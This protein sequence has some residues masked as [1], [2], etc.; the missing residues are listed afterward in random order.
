MQTWSVVRYDIDVLAQDWPTEMTGPIPDLVELLAR[1]RA[2]DRQRFL[3]RSDGFVDVRVNVFL[4]S[5]RMRMLASNTNRDYAQS[6]CLWLNFLQTRGRVWSEA[7]DE[8]VEDFEFWR[9]TDPSNPAPVG[10]SAFSKDVAACKKFYSWAA[11]RFS[12]IVDVFLCVD[13]P[14]SKRSA[15]VRWLDPAA[16]DRWRDVGLRGRD[17]RG[18]RIRSC[19]SAP[20]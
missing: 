17:L 1:W 12:D 10:A 16:V 20:R 8:D 5:A 7:I 9:R 14:P 3:I 2:V 4:S 6:L 15:R 13:S 19:G 18:R 11:E